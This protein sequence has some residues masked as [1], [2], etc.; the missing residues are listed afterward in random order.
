MAKI[1]RGFTDDNG[2]SMVYNLIAPFWAILAVKISIC[3]SLSRTALKDQTTLSISVNKA[4]WSSAQGAIV[5]SMAYRAARWP[6][7]VSLLLQL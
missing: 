1:P 3:R 6:V 7:L 2:A 5:G 4:L